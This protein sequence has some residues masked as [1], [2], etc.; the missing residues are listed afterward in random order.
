M[1]A[2]GRWLA[3]AAALLGW[4]F[5]GLEM[6]LFPQ[7]ARPALTELL[8][9]V[10]AGDID[11]WFGVITALFL[12]GAATGGVLFGWLGDRVGRV[13]AL[14][15]SVLIYAGCSGLSAFSPTPEAL[16]GLRFVGALGMGGEWALGVALVMELWPDASRGWLAAAIGAAGNLGYAL[17]GSIAFALNRVAGDLPGWLTAVGVP[18]DLAAKLTASGNWRLL[19]LVGALP[20]GLTLLVR[21]FVPESP[22]W[23]L[24]RGRGESPAADLLAVLGGAAAAVGIV[25]L[26]ANEVVMPVRIIATAAGLVVVTVCYLTPARRLLRA[27]GAT[28]AES[29]DTV[30]KMLLGAGLSSVPL[31]ATWA[32]FMWMYV[33]VDELTGKQNPDARPLTQIASSIGAAVGSVAGALLAVRFGRRPVYAGLCV[34]ALTMLVTFFRANDQFDTAF[35]VSAGLVG[36]ACAAFYGWLPLYLPEL[37]PTALRATGQGFA[38]NVGR[39]IAAVG[40]LQ[41]GALLGYFEGDYARACSLVAGVYLVG[42][43]L[44]VVAPE[45]RGRGLP[46]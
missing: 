35:L 33:W 22:R 39:V 14:T 40:T 4:L 36:A 32:G 13:R 29:R 30:R 16:A 1:S 8:G 28:P 44:I 37:F 21:L 6:G 18:T 43:G 34:V 19:M 26:W 2:A 7:V 12:V 46:G 11:R 3:L 41:T 24:T 15:L 25:F 31:I 38:F 9:P 45:T 23:L 20:A 42:L 5:D 17:V 10:Q 27:T